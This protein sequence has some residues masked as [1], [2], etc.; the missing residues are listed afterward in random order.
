LVVRAAVIFAVASVCVSLAGLGFELA[1]P[2][3]RDAQARVAAIVR[4]H[5]AQMDTLPLPTKLAAAVVAVEDEHFYSNVFV[6]MFDG[7]ARSAWATVH[8]S[9]DPGGSTIAQQLAKQLYPHRPG[10]SGTLDEIGLGLKLSV[11]F[12]KSQILGM[13]L[14]SIYYG[15]GYWGD[16][17]AARGY[18]GT[19]PDHLTWAEASMLAGLPQAP[20]A[21]DPVQHL[22]LAKHRQRHVLDLLVANRVISQAQADAAYLAPLHLRHG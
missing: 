18:F 20:S 11:T 13:Y 7:A 12:S 8:Q 14:N 10:L 22:A 17:T 16:T 15:N 3:V 19:D 4:A 2:S 6:N 9:G 1:L 21:Y 5:H